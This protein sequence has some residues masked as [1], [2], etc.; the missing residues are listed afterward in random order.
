MDVRKL[1]IA[2]RIRV[3]LLNPIIAVATQLQQMYENKQTNK[4]A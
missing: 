3:H 2:S 4:E 1:L